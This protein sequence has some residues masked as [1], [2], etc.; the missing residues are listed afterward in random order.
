MKSA[1]LSLGTKMAHKRTMP[2]LSHILDSEN[3]FYCACFAK[4]FLRQ[5]FGQTRLAKLPKAVIK[6]AAMQYR[7]KADLQLVYGADHDEATQEELLRWFHDDKSVELYL[8]S[9]SARPSKRSELLKGAAVH[10][11]HVRTS[12]RKRS[13]ALSYHPKQWEYHLHV[14]LSRTAR[15]SDAGVDTASLRTDVSCAALEVP[16][17]TSMCSNNSV[18]MRSIRKDSKL[19]VSEEFLLEWADKLT[20]FAAGFNLLADAAMFCWDNVKV[21]DELRIVIEAMRGAKIPKPTA[22]PSVACEVPHPAQQ[23]VPPVT[24]VPSLSA[25]LVTES[26][27][28]PQLASA[29]ACPGLTDAWMPSESEQAAANSIAERVWGKGCAARDFQAASLAAVHARRDVVCCVPTGA[30]KTGLCAILALGLPGVYI[31]LQPTRALQQA[32]A[33]TLWQVGIRCALLPIGG[34]A[35]R[36]VAA[37]QRGHVPTEQECKED[38]KVS[39]GMGSLPTIRESSHD[40]CVIISSPEQVLNSGALHLANGSSASNLRACIL[41]EAHLNDEW[42]HFRP[43]M[44]RMGSFRNAHPGVPFVLLSATLSSASQNVL[45]EQLC[46]SEPVDIRK[47]FALSS[48]IH[49]L[50]TVSSLDAVAAPPAGAA[51]LP[52]ALLS[53]PSSMEAAET[54]ALTEKLVSFSKVDAVSSILRNTAPGRSTLIFL[55]SKSGCKALCKLLN[56]SDQEHPRAVWHFSADTKQDSKIAQKNLELWMSGEVSVLIATIGMAVGVHNPLCHNVILY[57]PP[58]SLTQLVQMAGRCGRGLNKGFTYL[59]F[60]S[61]DCQERWRLLDQTHK[62]LMRSG[63]LSEESSLLAVKQQRATLAA[64]HEVELC[65]NAHTQLCAEQRAVWLEETCAAYF[66]FGESVAG[67]RPDPDSSC[68]DLQPF[69]YD[70]AIFLHNSRHSGVSVRALCEGVQNGVMPSLRADICESIAGEAYNKKLQR[71][72]L[73][74]YEAGVNS[75]SVAQIL[76]RGFDAGMFMLQYGPTGCTHVR[77]GGTSLRS[78]PMPVWVKLAPR[79]L[80]ISASSS[81]SDVAASVVI[82]AGSGGQS[83]TTV[84]VLKRE[85]PL[86]DINVRV[87]SGHASTASDAFSQA[88]AEQGACFVFER[89][90]VAANGE[91][92]AM[93]KCKSCGAVSD[94]QCKARAHIILYPETSNFLLKFTGT[95]SHQGALEPPLMC[96]VGEH[97]DKQERY[98]CYQSLPKHPTAKS[99]IEYEAQNNL[100]ASPMSVQ[101]ALLQRMVHSSSC[102]TTPFDTEPDDWKALNHAGEQVIALAGLG[103]KHGL[104]VRIPHVKQI[105]YIL[106]T[107]RHLDRGNKGTWAAFHAEI[108]KHGAFTSRNSIGE[109]GST[110]DSWIFVQSSQMRRLSETPAYA[111]AANI[112][113]YED[114]TG[115]VVRFRSKLFVYMIKSP[116]SGAG[117]PLAYMLYTSAAGKGAAFRTDGL[118]QALVWSYELIENNSQGHIQL[119]AKMMDKCTHGKAAWS[120][121]QANK[122]RGVLQS[123]RKYLE[124]EAPHL[125]DHQRCKLL[126]RTLQIEA[127]LQAVPSLVSEVAPSADAVRGALWEPV[128]EAVDHLSVLLLDPVL[129]TACHGN[130]ALLRDL[131]VCAQIQLFLCH[132]HALKAANENLLGKVSLEEDKSKLSCDLKALFRSVDELELHAAI[133]KIEHRWLNDYP[134]VISYLEKNW[135]SERWLRMWAPW[136][137]DDRDMDFTTNLVESHWQVLKYKVLKRRVNLC[138]IKLFRYLVGFSDTV[139]DTLVG[140]ILHKE[141]VAAAGLGSR[142]RIVLQREARR[143]LGAD[144]YNTHTS[145]LALGQKGLIKLI[146]RDSLMFAVQ[147]LTKQ[148]VSYVCSLR[149]RRGGELVATCDCPTSTRGTCKHVM[150]CV[151][152]SQKHFRENSVSHLQ[153]LAG[154]TAIQSLNKQRPKARQTSHQNKPSETK[155]HAQFS[156]DKEVHAAVK[157]LDHL[158]ASISYE[159]TLSGS[160]FEDIVAKLLG[161]PAV[162]SVALASTS[163]TQYAAQTQATGHISNTLRRAAASGGTP[164]NCLRIDHRL[165]RR[166][167]TQSDTTHSAT[168]TEADQAPPYISVGPGAEHASAATQE[169]NANGGPGTLQGILAQGDKACY[170][171]PQLPANPH[172]KMSAPVRNRSLS[173]SMVRAAGR[174]ASIMEQQCYNAGSLLTVSLNQPVLCSRGFRHTNAY[175]ICL[176]LPEDQIQHGGTYGHVHWLGSGGEALP[177]TDYERRRLRGQQRKA[178]GSIMHIIRDKHAPSALKFLAT[179]VDIHK[180]TLAQVPENHAQEW[181]QYVVDTWNLPEQ[182]SKV[183]PVRLR[184]RGVKRLLDPTPALQG[185]T[186]KQAKTDQSV[187]PPFHEHVLGRGGEENSHTTGDTIA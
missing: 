22:A 35:S 175:G 101:R 1:A 47:K 42:S 138:P 82:S 12:D 107:Q 65:F 102:V 106:D 99:I 43:D 51:Q 92:S 157:V 185:K 133:Q 28:L 73:R 109:P 118:V 66:T 6:L 97:P 180:Q 103:H 78:E 119:T 132:F 126:S 24:S 179:Q 94:T 61:K 9:V 57:T 146:D 105:A 168:A 116:Y 76:R 45:Q 10:S 70:L 68:Y 134:F 14:S 139:G 184:R 86:V 104:H 135:C 145:Q 171:E 112:L 31:L 60:N 142:K 155:P 37:M 160:S 120:I 186:F 123:T 121:F 40:T 159:G 98:N 173:K 154:F 127:V 79:H 29:A 77:A 59:L 81:T 147:S 113:V 178:T 100:D 54:A 44:A 143:R 67:M 182:S 74:L 41:D 83:Q 95:H 136:M 111:R 33:F 58:S 114:D 72:I 56:S 148:H 172:Q 165:A 122:L 27:T 20:D 170:G 4:T 23:T 131:E 183:L 52:V 187:S 89:A 15:R 25:V 53:P 32:S 153:S 46:M 19:A 39:G 110:N 144:I 80:R 156:G 18:Q 87:I 11:T 90:Q 174:R 149:V 169:V 55:N 75:L 38:M 91:P 161:A 3:G 8:G 50:P 128:Q 5:A 164:A 117:V 13:V 125:A 129:Q 88:A 108:A 151:T 152:F 167:S 69:L 64:F 84:D 137:R 26:T 7:A 176:F 150:A 124:Q 158:V 166:R 130:Q 162:D 163:I 62:S 181:A 63:Q 96:V 93:Y 2:V 71:Q 36:C 115:G 85:D 30:G 49:I 21:K 140:Y 141:Q 48:E 16:Y 34:K 177:I 17:V